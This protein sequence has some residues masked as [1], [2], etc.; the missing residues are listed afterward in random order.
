MKFLWR[1]VLTLLAAPFI[2]ALMALVLVLVP[3][4]SYF[5]SLKDQ[6]VE[7][8]V[9]TNGVHTDIVV[10]I[11]SETINWSTHFPASHFQGINPALMTHVAFGWG[12]RGFFLETPTWSDLEA[13]TAINALFLKSNT[14]MHV[15]YLPDPVPSE[16]V[17]RVYISESQ[18]AKLVNLISTS[19]ARD[20]NNDLEWIT[21]SGYRRNDTFYAANGSYHL[22]NTCND[23]T[24]RVLRKTGVKMSVWTPFSQSV[25]FYL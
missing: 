10:P 22:F 12:D 20:N 15:T 14:A 21:N 19:F 23:W 1:G 4:N 5:V 25:F 11:V 3:V 24:G 2:Y 13:S 18:Y 16:T 9:S 17:K 7:I 6:G 8:F